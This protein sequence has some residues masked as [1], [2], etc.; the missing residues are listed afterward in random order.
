VIGGMLNIDNYVCK[1]QSAML[2]EM[3]FIMMLLKSLLQV[4]ERGHSEAQ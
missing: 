4:K 1:V 3:L 2:W